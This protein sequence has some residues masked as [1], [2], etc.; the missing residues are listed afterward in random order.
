V[1]ATGENRG[2]SRVLRYWWVLPVGLALLA[3]VGLVVG[4]TLR[5]RLQQPTIVSEMCSPQPCAAPK[6]F[7]V[8]ISDVHSAAG[9]TSLQARFKN[10]TAADL[11]TTNY[12]PTSPRDFELRLKDGSRLLPVLTAGCPD[13][14]ELHVERGGSAGPV[15]V[16]FGT[17][18]TAGASV[19]WSPDL[20]LFFDEVRIPL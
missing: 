12:R 10:R 9:M 1:K 14:G 13:W 20:G 5:G 11:G 3:A 6:G 17:T 8:D 19:V 2:V 4:P 7:E 18:S 15:K 16:C